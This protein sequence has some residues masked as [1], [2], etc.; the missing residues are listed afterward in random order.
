M[1]APRGGG[2]ARRALRFAKLLRH[3]DRMRLIALLVALAL[4]PVSALAQTGPVQSAA[5]AYALLQQDVTDL[6]DA[7][8][9]SAE[10]LDLALER[11]AR[12]DPARVSRDRRRLLRALEA[13]CGQLG[14]LPCY[15]SCGAI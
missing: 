10:A 6:L 2:K 9:A 11:A 3:E 8:I 1:A 5:G 12:H 4:W 14:A 15:G 13:A 7:D